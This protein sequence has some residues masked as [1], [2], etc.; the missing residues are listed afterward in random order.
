MDQYKDIIL[1]DKDGDRFYT[2]KPFIRKTPKVIHEI[3]D[4]TLVEKTVEVEQ[5]FGHSLWDI[6]DESQPAM[7][8][9]LKERQACLDFVINAKG[10][11]LVFGL[12]IGLIIKAIENNPNVTSIRVIEKHDWVIEQ[13]KAQV[14]F[15]PKVTIEKGDMFTYIP[16]RK[17]KTIY[18]DIWA[19]SYDEAEYTA[20]GILRD[21]AQVMQEL[22]PFLEEGAG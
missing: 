16:T 5:A 15:G 21:R 17:Y 3:V 12:G 9:C 6:K 19:P 14:G 13:I 2:R 18:I 4:G 10:D 1:I 11:I 8:D 22:K 20:Q 7:E